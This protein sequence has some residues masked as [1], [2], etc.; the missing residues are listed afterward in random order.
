[1]VNWMLLYVA[2]LRGVNVGGHAR[3]SMEELRECFDSLGFENARTFIQSGN[4]VFQRGK[5]KGSSMVESLEEGIKARFG[6]EVRVLVR[7]SKEMS[8]I[9]ENSPFPAAQRDLTH[10]TFLASEP[11]SVPTK[12]IESLKDKK[13]KFLLS[14][15]EIYLICPNGYGM[16]K[17]SNSFLEKKLRVAATTRNWRTV[18]VLYNM[19]SE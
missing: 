6:F 10:V 17:L 11:E 18:N 15:R 13:D 4:V 5:A 9:I 2:L 8:R 1:M 12:E 3:I 14:G 16:Y 7:N 19:M